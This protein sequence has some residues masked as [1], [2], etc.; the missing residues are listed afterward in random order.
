LV[1]TVRPRCGRSGSTR[2]R[3]EIRDVGRTRRSCD[4]VGETGTLRLRLLVLDL[5]DGARDARVL[6]APARKMFTSDMA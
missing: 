3:A 5:I 4:T 1:G 2:G 6:E